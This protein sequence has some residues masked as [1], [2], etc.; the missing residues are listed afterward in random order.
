MNKCVVLHGL[1]FKCKNVVHRNIS[2]FANYALF[3]IAKK[4][5]S[6]HFWGKCRI[7]R[8]GILT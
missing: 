7:I 2:N 1:V 8:S 4:T 5:I 6:V 3:L